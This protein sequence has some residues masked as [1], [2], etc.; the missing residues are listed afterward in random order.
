MLP[1]TMRFT[2]VLAAGL[3][4]LGAA[5]AAAGED[6]PEHALAPRVKV[7]H[8]ERRDLAG[9]SANLVYSDPWLAYVLGRALA[10]RTYDA[11]DGASKQAIESVDPAH[12]AV[13]VKGQATC[14]SC[15][16]QG[17]VEGG[18]GLCRDR[19]GK[20]HDVPHYFGAGQI[21]MIADAIRRESLQQLDANGDGWISLEEAEGSELWIAPAPGEAKL[22]FGR[23]DDLDHDGR[24]DLDP[25]FDVWMVDAAGQPLESERLSD[26]L[27]A[28]FG[29]RVA[30]FDHG[31]RHRTSSL[32]AVVAHALEVPLGVQPHDPS[33]DGDPD[34]D[35]IAGYSIAGALQ[36][37]RDR[38]A[39]RGLQRTSTG[40]SLDDPDRD[41][42]CEEM[43]EG[44]VD[45]LEWYVLNLPQPAVVEPSGLARRGEL[46][47]DDYRCTQCHV[48]EWSFPGGRVDQGDVRVDRRFFEARVRQSMISLAMRA[49]IVALTVPSGTDSPRRFPPLQVHGVFTDL[50]VHN[51]GD[52]APRLARTRPLW[53]VGSS[54]PYLADGSAATLQEAILKHGGEAS[55]SRSSF[56]SASSEDQ[57]ALLAFLQGLVLFRAEDLA[58]SVTDPGEVSPAGAGHF[59]PE[60]WT[61]AY[62]RCWERQN[63]QVPFPLPPEAYGLDLPFL[64]DRDHD[65]LPDA[66]DPTPDNPGIAA[67][68][69]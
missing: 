37:T 31:M 66:I 5:I 18:P 60:L 13:A 69:D 41:G 45:L 36:F 30:P 11:V 17:R 62:R 52:R 42:V 58:T 15:H 27:V 3:L 51:L 2:G 23:G 53:G 48:S 26:P 7:V 8:S 6:A 68:R 1:P 50:R 63:G 39:D 34:G 16:G 9:T 44:E 57:A 22:F 65:S 46:L 10:L 55:A 32:R 33:F 24:P 4:G 25:I 56:Q 21:E 64:R 19:S 20:L 14:A 49:D 29:L 43:S 38:V 12:P 59:A 28:G 40:I 35:G 67:A 61:K 54:A 47:L